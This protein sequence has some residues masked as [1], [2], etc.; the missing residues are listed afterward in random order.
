MVD[1]AESERN[2]PA[3]S[4]EVGAPDGNEIEITP[5]MIEAG[6]GVI[7]WWESEEFSEWYEN[8]STIMTPHQALARELW[9]AMQAARQ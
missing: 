4:K 5:Q 1:K 3:T 6:V 2:I 8:S 7:S 9:F